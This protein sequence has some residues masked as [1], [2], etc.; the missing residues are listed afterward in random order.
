[1]HDFN[2][3]ALAPSRT[4]S[5]GRTEDEALFTKRGLF[6]LPFPGGED[7][8]CFGHWLPCF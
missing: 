3:L 4:A 6:P 5:P 2:H 7:A 8:I 1:M